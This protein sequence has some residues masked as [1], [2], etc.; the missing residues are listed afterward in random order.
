[1][2][3]E[4]LR[5]VI[6]RKLELSQMAESGFR[7]KDLPPYAYTSICPDPHYRIGEPSETNK[8]RDQEKDHK[9]K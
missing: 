1:M 2:S 9:R 3:H 4:K 8:R 7:S 5:K 6:E